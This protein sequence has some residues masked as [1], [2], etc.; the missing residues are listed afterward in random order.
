MSEKICETC[1]YQLE[2][3]YQD[4]KN[5]C[6]KYDKK[7]EPQPTGGLMGWICPKC[8]VV[9]SPYQSYCIKCSGG[10]KITYGTGTAPQ[11]SDAYIVESFERPGDQ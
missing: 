6:P 10:S 3:E 7:P 11:F 2:Y 4:A 1:A 9:M 5:F 8:G